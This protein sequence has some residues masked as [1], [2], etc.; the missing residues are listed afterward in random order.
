M[1]SL[2]HRRRELELD[3][4]AFTR[5]LRA[6]RPPFTWFLAQPPDT[7]EAL[8]RLGDE[9]MQGHALDV[10]YAVQNPAVAEAGLHAVDD[11][12]AEET[13]ARALALGVA[14]RIAGKGPESPV[15]APEPPPAP[16]LAGVGKRRQ[17]AAER[18]QQAKDRG[19]RFLGR[20]P[21][22]AGGVVAP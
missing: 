14:Q 21:D 20:Q 11:P 8:A 17:A 6:L 13:L 22:A 16:T 5:W 3:E 2:F 10:G 15:A 7:Q 4:A 18:R 9:W 1:F 12:A 19:R